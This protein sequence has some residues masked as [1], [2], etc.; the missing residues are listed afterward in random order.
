MDEDIME[1]KVSQGSGPGKKS[2][3]GVV[4]SLETSTRRILKAITNESPV[5][6]KEVAGESPMAADKVKGLITR[7]EAVHT[8]LSDIAYR[9]EK[10]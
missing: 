6:K 10:I 8:K 2:L 9:L 3:S 5:S 7:L 4:N 1:S